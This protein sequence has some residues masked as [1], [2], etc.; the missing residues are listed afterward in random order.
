MHIYNLLI[1]SLSCQLV[2]FRVT[3]VDIA[4]PNLCW[5]KTGLPSQQILEPPLITTRCR[6][7]RLIGD[8]VNTCTRMNIIY[9]TRWLYMVLR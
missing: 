3:I 7:Q 4:Y 8:S 2:L 6:W 5:P 9:E 1:L